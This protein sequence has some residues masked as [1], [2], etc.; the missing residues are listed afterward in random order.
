MLSK[1]RLTAT[2]MAFVLGIGGLT[3]AGAKPAAASSEKLWRYGTY[4][5][6]LGTGAALLKRKGTWALVGAGVTAL[7]YSQWRRSVRRRHAAERRARYA[8]YQSVRGYRGYSSSRYGRGYSSSRYRRYRTVR[9][10]HSRYARGR[11][12][13]CR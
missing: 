2:L 3:L 10:S 5:G 11:R 12:A 6:A 13:R 1:Q 7:S 8:S 4:L 9:K